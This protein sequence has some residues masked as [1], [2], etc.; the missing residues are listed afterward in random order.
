MELFTEQTETGPLFLD[1]KTGEDP[2]AQTIAASP[3]T[4]T[5][6]I[7]RSSMMAAVEEVPVSE[8]DADPQ[9]YMALLSE[10]KGL[11]Q[12]RIQMLGDS[13]IRLEMAHKERLEEV[14]DALALSRETEDEYEKWGA[15]QYAQHAAQQDMVEKSKTAPEKRTMDAIERIAQRDPYAA[16]MFSREQEIGDTTRDSLREEGARR[17]V[18]QN[19]LDG[20]KEEDNRNMAHKVFDWTADNIL[21]PLDKGLDITGNIDVEGKK[22]GKIKNFFLPGE[23]RE[24]EAFRLSQVP[25]NELPA[26]LEATKMAYEDA[27]TLFKYTNKTELKEQLGELVN[28]NK[29]IGGTNLM[30]SIEI[31]SI[32]PVTKSATVTSTMIR[33]GARKQATELAATAARIAETEGIEA[34]AKATGMESTEIYESLLPAVLK[35]VMDD[36]LS[37]IS[38]DAGGAYAAGREGMEKIVKANT[39]S[40][41]GANE[42]EALEGS[43]EPQAKRAFGDAVKDVKLKWETTSTGSQVPINRAIVGSLKGEGGYASEE[44]LKSAVDKYGVAYKPWKDESGEWFAVA[45]LPIKE[46]GFYTAPLKVNASTVISKFLR[47]GGM[48]GDDALQGAAIQGGRLA[49]KIQSGFEELSY[50]NYGKLARKDRKVLDEIFEAGRD[51]EEGWLTTVQLQKRWEEQTGNKISPKA[52]GAYYDFKRIMD[53]TY[54]I[55]NQDVYK[56]KALEGKETIALPANLGKGSAK[57]SRDMGDIPESRVFDVSDNK[58]YAKDLGTQMGPE[59]WKKLKD[60]GYMKVTFDEPVS[61]PDGTKV[62]EV[63]G[64]KS[65]FEV[66]PLAH[67]QVPYKAGIHRMYEDRFFA[68]AA[69]RLTQGDTGKTVLGSPKAYR[70]FPSQKMADEWVSTMNAAAKVYK[71]NAGDLAGLAKVFGGR[72]EYPSPEEFINSIKQGKFNPDE[73]LEAV[74]DGVLPSAYTGDLSETRFFSDPEASSLEMLGTTQGRMYTSS[75]GDRLVGYDGKEAPVLSPAKTINRA[76]NDAAR[77]AGFSDYVMESTNRMLTSFD[78][79]IDPKSVAH[80]LSPQAKVQYGKL[81]KGTDSKIVAQWE[82]QRSIIGRVL[83]QKTASDEIMD[84]FNRSLQNRLAGSGVLDTLTGGK[85]INIARWVDEANPL[86]AMRGFAFHTKLGLFNVAQFPLQASSSFQAALLS[87]DWLEINPFQAYAG[88]VLLRFAHEYGPNAS[89]V[90]DNPRLLK[91]MGFKD[92]ASAK[93]AVEAFSESGLLNVNNSHQL[94]NTKTGGLIGAGRYGAAYEKGKKASGIFFY[95]PEKIN[96]S[97]AFMVAWREVEKDLGKRLLRTD[98]ASMKKVFDK[99][100]T[101]SFQMAA[102]SRSAFQKGPASLATQ[103]FSYPIRMLELTFSGNKLSSS[104]KA[105]LLAGQLTMYG[106]AGFVGT[107]IISDK[108]QT[109]TGETPKKGT[110]GYVLDR[111]LVDTMINMGVF[112][113]DD[114]DINVSDRIGTG[115]FATDLFKEL[116]NQ[117][118][119]GDT[120]FLGAVSGVGGQTVKDSY[121]AFNSLFKYSVALNGDFTHPLMKDAMIDVARDVSSV[122]NAYRGTMAI[123][124]QLLYSK[125]GNLIDSDVTTPEAFALL[126]GI[127][128]NTMND[129]G[130]MMEH[131]KRDKETVE[132]TSKLVS[133]YLKDAILL[134]HTQDSSYSKISTLEN[135]IDDPLLWEKIVKQSERYHNTDSL[136]ESISKRHE[137]EKS[138]K[139]M[140]E[141]IEKR[142]KERDNK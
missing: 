58:H 135:I 62:L 105:K 36:G 96:R 49:D 23:R 15:V 99:T 10:T 140:R 112:G 41:L 21:F 52:E 68:K 122:N 61:L 114:T 7:H 108:I 101:Y 48:Q 27:A 4:V 70:T 25:L 119:Y 14:R 121:E 81:K 82:A 116:V 18:Y 47:A 90:L 56:R 63:I 131:G 129:V 98:G 123:K 115:A 84:N 55:R 137:D 102:E 89:K 133:K 78:K 69:T 59:K 95:E 74:E 11:Y 51:T 3:T 113:S 66:S 65:D 77:I 111:G 9:N 24:A 28:N 45:R 75:R 72:S 50:R 120:S 124:Q 19:F 79:H 31:A 17:L 34:A 73:A 29:S 1:P 106:S 26:F 92:K 8:L 109:S 100:E 35:N 30:Q 46:E 107:E 76:A 117:S 6:Q 33:G 88:G 127:N 2:K 128:N 132:E 136:V 16:A 93:E 44:A 83:N 20:L 87:P 12:E 53:I 13:Q 39:R 57:V 43:L 125:T 142:I 40:R 118:P 138:R 64:K 37:G 139:A 134:P 54:H 71:E 42:R 104:Q 86:A 141:R 22:A 85:A 130:A 94:A 32:L 67:I 80:V 103:F 126:A 38:T 110:V 97:V 60:K 5:P 91:S